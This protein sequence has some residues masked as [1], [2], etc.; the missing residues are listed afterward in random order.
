[1][2]RHSLPSSPSLLPSPSPHAVLSCTCMY[3]CFC[4]FQW[5]FYIISTLLTPPPIAHIPPGPPA[6]CLQCSHNAVD[7]FSFI[8]CGCRCRLGHVPLGLREGGWARGKG[9]DSARTSGHG[10]LLLFI[11]AVLIQR[12]YLGTWE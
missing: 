6:I 4:V 1:M 9:S 7:A 12:W 10:T 2:P 5:F 3:F 11:T 8:A